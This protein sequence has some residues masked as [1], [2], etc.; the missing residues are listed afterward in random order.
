MSQPPANQP[1]SAD[2]PLLTVACAILL[3]IDFRTRSTMTA[4]ERAQA[5]SD[6]VDGVMTLWT[7]IQQRI[8]TGVLLAP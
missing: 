8:A 2:A 1:T 7:E 4:D 3:L 5:S 6:A